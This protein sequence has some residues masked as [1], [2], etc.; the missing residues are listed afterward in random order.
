MEDN[1]Q[2]KEV[3]STFQAANKLFSV[4]L[5]IG[6]VESGG[7]KAAVSTKQPEKAR[8]KPETVEAN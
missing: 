4:S 3:G 2:L 8:V 7:D 5:T 6:P 1:L